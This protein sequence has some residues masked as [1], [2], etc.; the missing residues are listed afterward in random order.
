MEF[1]KECIQNLIGCLWSSD[2][3]LSATECAQLSSTVCEKSTNTLKDKCE[4]DTKSNKCN[5][6]IVKSC[7]EYTMESDCKSSSFGCQWSSNKCLSAT[8][9][10]Q[11]S[12]SVCEKST[13][14]LRYLCEWDSKNNSCKKKKL[15]EEFNDSTECN[16]SIL[17]CQW[18]YEKCINYFSCNQLSFHLY[19]YTTGKY[20]DKCEWAINGYNE[21]Y[22]ISKRTSALN[23]NENVNELDCKRSILGCYWYKDECIEAE[24]CN[25]LK[26]IPACLNNTGP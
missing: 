20:K 15:C 7:D 10:A 4:W 1:E 18:Y 2:K 25:D 13:N 11:L 16:N 3:C 12:S 9:C 5:G 22:C 8:E 21:N 26:D 14:S 17:G 24:Q 6:K 19:D 23:C